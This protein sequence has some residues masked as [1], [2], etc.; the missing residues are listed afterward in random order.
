MKFLGLINPEKVS[1]AEAEAYTVREAVRA[2]VVDGEGR[3]AWL[4]VGQNKFYK[5]PGG[6][7]E[8]GESRMET[9]E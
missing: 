2:V 1:E 9:L 4:Y 8:P 3:V 5:L 6:G 7:V